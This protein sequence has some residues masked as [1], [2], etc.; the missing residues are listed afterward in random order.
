MA[1]PSHQVQWCALWV[2]ADKIGSEP[3]MNHAEARLGLC[4]RNGL[5]SW[6]YPLCPEMVAFLSEHIP[7]SGKIAGVLIEFAL[8]CIFSDSERTN[9]L[10][11]ATSSS[12]WFNEQLF[13]KV[14]EHMEVNVDD[15][16]ITRCKFHD[17]ER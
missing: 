8:Y 12:D 16:E 3:L 2:L 15:C 5:A 13:N 11:K 17:F 10:G 1:L 6:D 9:G 7:E 14:K 4:L